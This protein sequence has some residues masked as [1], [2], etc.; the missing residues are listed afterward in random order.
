M[1]TTNQMLKKLGYACLFM[2]GHEEAAA[3]LYRL[4]AR[5]ECGF[6]EGRKRWHELLIALS[7]AGGLAAELNRFGTTF[8]EQ[9]WQA[10]ITDLLPRLAS[11]PQPPL[12]HATAANAASPVESLPTTASAPPLPPDDLFWSESRIEAVCMTNDRLEVLADSV[13]L[14]ADNMPRAVR[15][16]F[17]GVAR[18]TKTLFE[19]IG[20]PRN[21]AGFREPSKVEEFHI[22]QMSSACKIYTIEGIT[23]FAPI[24]WLEIEIVASGGHAWPR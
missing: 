4:I 20:D 18:V 19:Y 6:D 1:T 8:S 3:T 21:Q 24:G 12:S 15:L 23:T 14:P 10:L 7:N 22:A 11:A 17:D 5:G 9:E 2:P 13:F 16:V